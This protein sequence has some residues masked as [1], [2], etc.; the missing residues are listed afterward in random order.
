MPKPTDAE[1]AAYRA[2]LERIVAEA[3]APFQDFEASRLEAFLKPQFPLRMI[4]DNLG[5]P[6]VTVRNWLTR[7]Q[8]DIQAQE[9][10]T[11]GK[12]RLFSE[13]DVIIIATAFQLSR[14]GIPVALLEETS[15]RV[16][17]LANAMLV[18]VTGMMRK[19]VLLLWNDGEWHV[20]TSFDSGPV[21]VTEVAPAPVFMVV[22]AE[23][24]ITGTLAKLGIHIKRV[25]G[26]G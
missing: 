14:M 3:K 5:I 15:G 7:G 4:T 24:L 20:T 26:A 17:E 6:E 9:G 18:K 13:R 11:K 16:A 2:E 23:A 8:L 12:W 10:R 25:G 19:P 22:D 1:K 21:H